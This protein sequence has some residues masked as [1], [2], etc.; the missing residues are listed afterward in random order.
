MDETFML[1]DE[2]TLGLTLADLEKP[3]HITLTTYDLDMTLFMAEFYDPDIEYDVWYWLA[4][5]QRTLPENVHL[6]QLN[7]LHCKFWY[8]KTPGQAR[9]IITSTNITYQMVHGCLQSYYACTAPLSKSHTT[10]HHSGNHPTGNHPT[11]NHPS[12]PFFAIFN[13]DLEEPLLSRVGARLVY[14]IPNKCNAIE[15]WYLAQKS[16]TVDANN[17]NLAYLDGIKRKVLIRSELPPAVS[18]IVCYYRLDHTSPNLTILSQPYAALYHYKLYAAD[19]TLLVTSN[20]FS[21]HHKLNYELGI[22]LHSA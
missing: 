3:T 9:L 11:G 2:F 4:T 20:N 15:K 10:N 1:I 16:L 7:N 21:Y 8:I 18:T 13:V 17:I 14:N 12:H 6:H 5:R 22:I 19:N